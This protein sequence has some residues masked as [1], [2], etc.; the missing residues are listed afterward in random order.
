[1]T[2]AS[3][4]PPLSRFSFLWALILGCLALAACQGT[5]PSSQPSPTASPTATLSPTATPSPLAL[6][7]LIS[8]D[9]AYRHLLVLADDIGSR[10]A[11]SQAERQAAQY[12]SQQLTTYGYQTQMQEFTLE[13]YVETAALEVVTPTPLSLNPN[14]LRLSAGG[15]VTADVVS[16]GLGRP[17]DFPPEGSNGRVA[18]VERGELSFSE[19][20]T[21]AAANGAAAVIIYNNVEG[22]L[23]GELQEESPIPALSLSQAEGRQIQALLKEGP[24]TVHL[25]A[26]SGRE[27]RTSQNV[28]GRPPQDDCQIIVGAHYDS[29]AE[30]PGAND[31]A[32][33]SAALLEIA[34]VLDLR[35]QE[36][37]VCFVAFGAEETGLFGSRHFVASLAS[38]DQPSPQAMVNLDMVGVGAEWQLLGSPSLVET[39]DQEAAELGLDPVPTEPNLQS[40]HISFMD[41]GIPAVLIHRVEDPRQHTESDRAEFVQSQLLEEAAKLT[42]LALAELSSP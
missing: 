33:G 34:R 6:A 26:Q 5:E 4:T 21:N 23:Q 24:L 38:Q 28:I 11:G 27:T 30:G 29:V 40:D 12:I 17:Q 16:A 9:Q 1:L 10:P 25:L 42:L 2:P 7:S 35:G 18:L 39:I 15:E 36:E 20:V 3:F 8:G 13:Y 22:P 14:A 41:A 19:K 37:G 32:S 31:N